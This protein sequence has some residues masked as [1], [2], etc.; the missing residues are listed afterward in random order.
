VLYADR[1]RFP[2]TTRVIITYWGRWLVHFI[3]W[4]KVRMGGTVKDKAKHLRANMTDTER[5]LWKHLRLRQLQGFKFRRQAT[6][7][8]YI[9]D[10]VSFEAGLIIEVDGGHHAGQKVKDSRRTSWLNKQGFRVLRFWD[11]EVLKETRSVLEASWKELSPRLNPP[12]Q[13]GGREQGRQPIA[14]RHEP[15]L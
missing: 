14:T 2:G 4:G 6:I 10:F 9:A 13:G 5:L 7:G 3:L 8:P 12:P 1:F 11:T 15:G